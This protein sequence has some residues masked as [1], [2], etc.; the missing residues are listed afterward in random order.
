LRPIG[1]GINSE[2]PWLSSHANEAYGVG[3]PAELAKSVNLYG[4]RFPF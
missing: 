1:Q 2:L 4:L 3:I